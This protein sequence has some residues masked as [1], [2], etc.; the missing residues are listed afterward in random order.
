MSS[1][2]TL[3]VPKP[4]HLLCPTCHWPFQWDGIGNGD[5]C[6]TGGCRAY[7]HMDNGIN[8][9]QAEEAR[10]LKFFEMSSG[11]KITEFDYI[12]KNCGGIVGIMKGGIWVCE[13]CKLKSSLKELL[14]ETP[15]TR[16]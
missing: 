10:Q 14:K 4:T 6:P 16:S 3:N 8:A 13:K 9:E 2:Q 15:K 1:D 12:H 5:T 7:V 11:F